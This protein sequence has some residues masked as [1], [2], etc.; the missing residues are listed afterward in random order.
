MVYLPTF[1]SYVVA[2]PAV[3]IR[4]II[5][6][7]RILCQ[8]RTTFPSPKNPP[9]LTLGFANQ[10]PQFLSAQNFDRAC[11]LGYTTNAGDIVIPSD[12]TSFFSTEIVK[13][14]WT[15]TLSNLFSK[16]EAFFLVGKDKALEFLK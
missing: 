1:R 3:A 5:N 6:C 11:D 9:Q 15:Q 4:F 2:S 12:L 10:P 8:I 13:Q 7:P 14:K 16:K